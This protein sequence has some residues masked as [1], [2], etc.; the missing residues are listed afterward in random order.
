[1]TKIYDQKAKGAQI[2]SR[3]KWVELG[4]KNNAYFLGLEKQRQVKKSINK[5]SDDNGNIITDQTDLLNKIKHYYA[6]LY[7][8]N[9]PDKSLL[10]QNIFETNLEKKLNDH[11]KSICDGTLTVDECSDAIFH[12]KLNKTPGLD[13]LTVEFYRKFWGKMKDF[14]VS[15]LNKGYD[16]SLLTFS[17]RTSV[18]SL[19]FKKGDPLLLDNYCHISLFKC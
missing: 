19:I 16:E 8:A 10:E 2:R 14:V 4:E 1:M 7:K 18:L 9:Q 5:L 15:V 3:E 12:M 6:N 13:G 11:D 17:Q